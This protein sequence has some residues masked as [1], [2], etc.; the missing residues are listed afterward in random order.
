MCNKFFFRI[1]PRSVFN[2]GF[3]FEIIHE[4]SQ[5]CYFISGAPGSCT[6]L[7]ARAAW[8]GV[9]IPEEVINE[10]ALSTLILLSLLRYAAKM[11]L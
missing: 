1:I 4:T 6:T 7:S 8:V 3:C 5:F 11:P 9:K 10:A 2:C